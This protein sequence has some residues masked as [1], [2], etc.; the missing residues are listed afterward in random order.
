VL[1]WAP[2]V[3]IISPCGFNLVS[4]SQQ[5]RQLF[6]RPGWNDLPAVHQNRVYAVDA[7]A[8]FARPGPR[9]IDGVMLLAHLIHPEL[10]EW[11]GP[12][13]AFESISLAAD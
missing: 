12:S 8:Y 1:N 2:E 7:N 6:A 13:A 3:L 9:L 5:A 4:A 11:T 10:C